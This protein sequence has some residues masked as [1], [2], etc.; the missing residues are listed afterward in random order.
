MPVG[1][2]LM[3]VKCDEFIPDYIYR[4][5]QLDDLIQTAFSKYYL[6]RKLNIQ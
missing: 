5:L 2:Q 4:A 3:E 6:C 1:M